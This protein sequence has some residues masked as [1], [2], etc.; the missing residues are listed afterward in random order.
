MRRFCAKCAWVFLV[1]THPTNL[2]LSLGIDNLLKC[3]P[4]C[5]RSRVILGSF[6][7][8]GLDCPSD[9]EG[10]QVVELVPVHWRFTH[11]QE[12]QQGSKIQARSCA[13][14]SNTRLSSAEI[15]SSGNVSSGSWDTT[16]S[17]LSAVRRAKFN[18]CQPQCRYQHGSICPAVQ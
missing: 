16:R 5:G 11:D 13:R 8:V 12:G 7:R 17:I 2:S 9:D 6:C 15:V 4:L 14:K 18:A 3:A 1:W 10:A